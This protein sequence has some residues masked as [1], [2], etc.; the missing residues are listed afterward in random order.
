MKHKGHG[1]SE[2]D[3][4]VQEEAAVNILGNVINEKWDGLEVTTESKQQVQMPKMRY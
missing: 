4:D 1:D 2:G 3:Q